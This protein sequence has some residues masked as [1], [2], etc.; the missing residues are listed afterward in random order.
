[1]NALLAEVLA[2]AVERVIDED[3]RLGMLTVTGVESD[4]DLRHAS[5]FFSSLPP[6]VAEALSEHRVALQRAIANER[7][8]EARR[9][10]SASCPTRPWRRAS[11]VEEA[12]RRIRR[13]DAEPG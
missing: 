13:R 1:M 6:D 8:A 11:R 5:V 9:R 2:D 4:P 7:Q 12:L 10:P 3:E